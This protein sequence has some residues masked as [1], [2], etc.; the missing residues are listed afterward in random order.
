MWRQLDDTLTCNQVK[1]MLGYLPD[2][3]GE[4]NSEP[5]KDQIAANYAHGGGYS[6][7]GKDKWIFDPVRKTL[8]YPG[9]PTLKPV[10]ELQ[11]RDELFIVYQ[12]AVCAI[13]QKDG[14][15]DVVRMD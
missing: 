9:D 11:V 4:F 1:G 12:Y 15:F 8:K 2:F 6:P 7:Y 13:V 3:I 10:A 5:I 14:S